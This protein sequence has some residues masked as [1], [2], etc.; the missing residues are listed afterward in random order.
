MLLQCTRLFP[1][2]LPPRT[3]SVTPVVIVVSLAYVIYNIKIGGWGCFFY[4]FHPLRY[5]DGPIAPPA[6]GPTR[7]TSTLLCTSR[8]VCAG[9]CAVGDKARYVILRLR[10][11]HV[12]VIIFF[13]TA[14]TY[15]CITCMRE[16]E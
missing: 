13:W 14:F 16:R 8:C 1:R 12:T 7:V 5:P 15:K 3:L 11:V 2:P 6:N 9:T 10:G 4:P